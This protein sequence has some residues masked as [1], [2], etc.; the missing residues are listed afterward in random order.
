[1][2][3]CFSNIFPHNKGKSQN[4]NKKF[5][6][7][8]Y[9]LHLPTDLHDADWEQS[10]YVIR[11]RGPG[12]I[13]QILLAEKYFSGLNYANLINNIW[14]HHREDLERETLLMRR[15]WRLGESVEEENYGRRQSRIPFNY[16]WRLVQHDL[17]LVIATMREGTRIVIC[18]DQNNNNDNSL[19]NY[20][21]IL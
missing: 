21:C 1:V 14:V 20:H 5:A 4:K 18:P 2:D 10:V 11:Q 13:A 6:S 9:H 8:R 17:L 15:W 16:W 3:S 12:F 19:S 7:V